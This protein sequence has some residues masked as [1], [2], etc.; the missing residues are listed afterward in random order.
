[1]NTKYERFDGCRGKIT[2]RCQKG[3]YIELDNGEGAFSFKCANLL[4]GTEVLCTILRNTID[5]KRIL[6]S[7]DSVLSYE[8]CR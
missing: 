3:A 5:N 7:V 4:P 2:S 6:V 8:Y 1:M